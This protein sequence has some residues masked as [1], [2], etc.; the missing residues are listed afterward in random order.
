[1]TLQ[2]NMDNKILKLLKKDSLTKDE[3]HILYVNGFDTEQI[4]CEH[5]E[6]IK[7]IKALA[8]QISLEKAAKG[9][10]YSISS[11]DMRYRT[12]ISSLIWARSLPEHIFEYIDRGNYNKE[13]KYCAVCD[14]FTA[15]KGEIVTV[16]PLSEH[17]TRIFP[18][19]CRFFTDICTAEY[20]YIDLLSFKPLPETGYT[21]EDIRI[22]NRIFGLAREVGSGNKATALLKLVSREKDI[23]LKQDN[24]YSILG[25]LSHCGVFDTPEYKSCASEFVPNFARG[26]EYESDCY[27]PL[28]YWRG[29]YGINYAA[30]EKA[31]GKE[32]SEKLSKDNAITGAGEVKPQKAIRSRAEQYF[33]EGRHF[34]EMNDR[35]RYYYGLSPLDPKW[36]KVTKFSATYD[37]YKRTELY[38]EGNIIKKMIYEEIVSKSGRREY[39]ESD[40]NVETIDREQIV[41]KTPRGRIQ[42]L[43]PSKLITPTYMQQ[44]LAVYLQDSSSAVVVSSFNSQNDRELPVYPIENTGFEDYTEKYIASC[45]PD[46]DKQLDAFRNKKRVT[47]KCDAGDI[48]RVQITPTLFTYAL[49]L[50]EVRKIEKWDELPRDHGMRRVMTKPII[51]RQYAIVTANA[52]MTPEQLEKYPLLGAKLAQDNFVHWETYPIIGHKM[53]KKADIQLY[54]A[55]DEQEKTVHWDMNTYHLDTV[56]DKI[57][58]GVS[59]ED[60][61]R[62][63]GRGVALYINV[64]GRYEEGELT[65]ETS[66]ADKLKERLIKFYGLDPD[67]PQDDMAVRFGGVTRQGYIDIAEKNK[68]K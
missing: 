63:G 1:M 31:F 50:G 48:F 5:N 36:E 38:F 57:F 64:K 51:F 19:R 58:D 12:A 20:V 2:N 52:C 56:F 15:V 59:K 46:Y 32:I 53:L 6:L 65:A 22:L 27:Y 33:T 30:I 34:V 17:Y 14:A 29:K 60:F 18:S 40:M 7:R 24:I 45:P 25:V 21:N 66:A 16:K 41:P 11:G 39:L 68:K 23:D 35:Q 62:C 55:V 10:L 4:N 28:N 9:F 26:F 13:K 42:P 49:I 8:G 54:F 37:Y 61:I 43:N 3:K 44:H 67:A 47:V